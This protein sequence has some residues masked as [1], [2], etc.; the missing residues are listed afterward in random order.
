MKM[1]DTGRSAQTVVILGAEASRGASFA[2][3][4]A[5]PPFLDND[6]FE[7][8]HLLTTRQADARRLRERL[9]SDFGSAPDVGME[10]FFT[11]VEYCR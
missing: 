2:D 8:T 7:L 5:F 9:Y 1:L 11:Y 3:D 10:E 6:F 4:A